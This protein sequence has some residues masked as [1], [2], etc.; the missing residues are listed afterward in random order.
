MRILILIFSIAP[1]M[2]FVGCVHHSAESVT[3][4]NAQANNAS[5]S[6][7][8]R[9]HA[10]FTL[11]ARHLRAGSS[12]AVVQHVLANTN[13]LGDTSLIAIPD[14]GPGLPIRVTSGDSAFVIHL[15]PTAGSEG[16]SPWVIYFRLTY[17]LRKEDALAF[18]CG[19]RLESDPKLVEFALCS[20][21][22]IE[23]FSHEGVHAYDL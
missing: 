9:A 17:D 2:T 7:A 13:W 4:L 3:A 15:F 11:F 16:Q 21:H 5:K 23:H 22:R 18:L 19:Q 12:A 14:S 6:Q 10:I 8:E 1:L 20:P